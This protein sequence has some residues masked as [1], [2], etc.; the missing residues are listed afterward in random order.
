M[1]FTNC[2][3][4]I[5]S[6]FSHR[7]VQCLENTCTLDNGNTGQCVRIEN[8]PS[9]IAQVRNKKN[10]PKRCRFD[11][12]HPIVCCEIKEDLQKLPPGTIS[13]QKCE[14][15]YPAIQQ[16]VLIPLKPIPLPLP[17]VTE[18]PSEFSSAPPAPEVVGGID[19]PPLT[20]THMAALGYGDYPDISWACGGSLI[21]EK[22][23]LTAAHCTKTLTGDVK[24]V[25]L[26]DLNINSTT[27]NAETQRFNVSK[28][29]NHPDY[30]APS[31]YNDIALLELSRRARF[32]LYVFPICL[33]TNPEIPKKD[34][35]ATGWGNLRFL[36]ERAHHL[37]QVTIHESSNETCKDAYASTTKR[38]LKNGIDFKTQL[39]AG[40]LNKDTCQGDSGGPLQINNAAGGFS[41]IGITSFGKACGIGNTPAVYTR[42]SH[43]V[44]WIESIVWA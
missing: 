1:L 36:G 14:E 28:I 32:N 5:L 18:A 41:L 33:Y 19:A 43:Y 21:S 10:M 39:C 6:L 25:R 13:K 2:L 31:V 11:G 37:Q 7:L 30:K 4:V 23:V 17:A 44:G 9:A 20:F 3:L 24:Y 34:W 12:K 35:I 22:Y 8:C 38:R 15:Y 42:V 27:N 26:G 29:I 40:A 16:P